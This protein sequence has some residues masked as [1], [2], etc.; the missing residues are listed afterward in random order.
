MEIIT[1]YFPDLSPQQKNR[2]ESLGGLYQDWNQKIN[3]ISRKDI[4]N[5][6]ERHIL[7]AL[8][9]AKII[10]FKKDAEIL[11]LGTGGGFPG[12]PLAVLF[13][14]TKFKL[15]DS[16]GKKLKVIEDISSK[17]GLKNIETQQIRGEKLQ[18]K[19]DFVIGR[20][21]C[22]LDEFVKMVK[23]NIKE[24]S[25]HQLKNGVLYFGSTGNIKD[26]DIL[27]N[28]IAYNI[29]DYFEEEY[30]KDRKV[31]YFKNVDFQKR[32]KKQETNKSQIKKSKLKTKAFGF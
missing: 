18:E 6:Y 11:D 31:L 21:V 20:A 12:L 15:V 8:A 17:L 30:F 26:K 29:S 25:Q 4:E 9:I 32:Y 1:K 28:S 16:I 13:H 27:E 5:L 19:F 24:E 22:P 3:L 14:G 7:N 23:N 10:E 2:F